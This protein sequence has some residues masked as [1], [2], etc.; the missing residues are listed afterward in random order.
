MRQSLARFSESGASCRMPW[1]ADCIT[2]TPGTRFSARTV[3]ARH[4]GGAA[5]PQAGAAAN[6]SRGIGCSRIAQWINAAN[7]PR[8]TEI[9]QIRS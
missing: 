3:A 4:A 5:A 9:H 8:P 6:A 2:D 1:L 7:A